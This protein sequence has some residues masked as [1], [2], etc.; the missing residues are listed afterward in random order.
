[1]HEMA[2]IQN[3]LRIVTE[4]GKKANS[5][6]VLKI[7]IRMGE[8]SD[9]VPQ[10]LREYFEIA[11]MDTIAEGAEIVL[12]RVPAVIRCRDCHWQGPVEHFHVVCKECG[13]TNIT[14]VSGRE[15]YV[16]S[17]EVQ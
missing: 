10:I 14:M 13:S 7:C 6:K 8:Y 1:M 3:V 17:I 12:N 2:I 5:Q 9:V 4:E 15:F 16:E 11:A